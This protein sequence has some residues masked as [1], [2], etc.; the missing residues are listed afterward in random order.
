MLPIG[1][2]FL[3]W[4]GATAI[5]AF[6][7]L[8]LLILAGRKAGPQVAASFGFGIFLWFFVDTIQSS[9]N[10]DVNLGFF[11]GAPE[12]T[13]ALLFVVGVT[14]FFAADRRSFTSAGEDQTIPFTVPLL[15]ALAAGLHGLG[16]GSAAGST[17]ALTSST[18]IV[19]AFGGAVGVVPY[20]LHKAL[21]PM[22]VGALY[23]A[24][25]SHRPPKSRGL[26]RDSPLIT[27]LFVLP[28][29]IGAWIGYFINYDAAYFF[30]LGTGSAVYVGLRLA[31]SVVT[32][33][34]REGRKQE[35]KLVAALL[36][37]FILIYVAALLHS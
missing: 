20:L 30:A 34:R 37:G 33:S 26:L 28:S 19:G 35:A 10:L 36:L 31:K 7:G 15:A 23:V 13:S 3:A 24:H 21:E 32:P 27:S 12:L 5:P 8:L 17:A 25:L 2:T 11:G 16:E 4:I 6:V 22:M 1:E 9:A 29:A 18:D 14:V